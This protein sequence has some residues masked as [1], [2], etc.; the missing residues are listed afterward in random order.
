M[1]LFPTPTVHLALTATATPAATA[2]LAD[3]LQLTRPK[4]VSTNPDRPNI[5]IEVI[6]KIKHS[7]SNVY[8]FRHEP[9]LEILL[10]IL[11]KSF[12]ALVIVVPSLI[13]LS[14]TFMIKYIFHIATRSIMFHKQI[15]F[16]VLINNSP[17]TRDCLLSDTKHM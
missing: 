12:G 16:N 3:I 10:S 2:E 5:F 13:S 7:N 8:V 15:C 6:F 14:I 4:T 17:K 11:N 9:I 1:C